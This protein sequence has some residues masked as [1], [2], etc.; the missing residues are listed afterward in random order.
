VRGPD[1][2]RPEREAFARQL[3]EELSRP[4]DVGGVA[5]QVRPVAGLA[6]FELAHHRARSRPA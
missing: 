3:I 4:F 5:T 6:E 1:G 2:S